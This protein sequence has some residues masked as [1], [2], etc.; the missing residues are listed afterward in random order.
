MHI[1]DLMEKLTVAGYNARV[2]IT[3]DLIGIYA[4]KPEVSIQIFGSEN[5]DV[6]KGSDKEFTEFRG[7]TALA[8]AMAFAG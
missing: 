6:M 7:P 1:A 5:I 4:R 3:P 8:E 2:Q